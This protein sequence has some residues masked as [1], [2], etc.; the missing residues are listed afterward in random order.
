MYTFRTNWNAYVLAFQN[1][2]LINKLYNIV[3]YYKEHH[4]G[5]RN[6]FKLILMYKIK[7][8]CMLWC[9]KLENFSLKFT[10]R[11][12]A[13]GGSF[14][15]CFYLVC[16]C[17][18][19]LIYL[20]CKNWNLTWLIIFYNTMIVCTGIGLHVW[21]LTRY[22]THNI[23]FGYFTRLR[24]KLIRYSFKNYLYENLEFLY[25][26]FLNCIYIILVKLILIV[27]NKK[28]KFYIHL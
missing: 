16:I 9:H 10:T 2:I 4:S 26:Y 23:V 8:Y 14:F 7:A 19:L 25:Y 6:T 3:C 27:W 21:T 1:N 24:K 5:R 12:A 18:Y 15:V 11:A 17:I 28:E 20:E 13:Y 22:I